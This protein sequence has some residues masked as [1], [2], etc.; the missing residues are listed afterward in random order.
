[1]KIASGTQS[2]TSSCSEGVTTAAGAVPISTLNTYKRTEGPCW[3]SAGKAKKDYP[4]TW[5]MNR[6]ATY[7]VTQEMETKQQPGTAGP[8]NMLGWCLVSLHFLCFILFGRTLCS[9]T[10][11][12]EFVYIHWW[13]N[14]WTG[15]LLTLPDVGRFFFKIDINTLGIRLPLYFMPLTFL[16]VRSFFRQSITFD[17]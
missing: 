1:M 6:V 9:F 17:P 14:L 11:V 3:R 4:L 2:R 5:N 13:A 7:D 16:A 15:G 12:I 10:S 8:G